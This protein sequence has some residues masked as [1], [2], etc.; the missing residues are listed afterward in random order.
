MILYVYIHHMP[1]LLS[2]AQISRRIISL[3]DEQ[4][5]VDSINKVARKSYRVLKKGKYCAVIVGD[6]R[7]R[8]NVVSFGFDLIQ[9][10]LNAGFKS[11]EI[12]IKE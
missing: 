2:T 12:I 6:K 4:A 5:F 10:F 8:D 11:K 7:Y 9:C 1:I 3:F